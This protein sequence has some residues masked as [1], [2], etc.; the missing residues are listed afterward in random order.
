MTDSPK[1]DLILFAVVVLVMTTVAVILVKRFI[2]S[3][4]DE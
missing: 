2:R 4:E 1:T 3:D